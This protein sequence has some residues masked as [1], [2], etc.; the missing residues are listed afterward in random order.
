MR[1]QLVQVRGACITARHQHD[2]V[3]LKVFEA[4]RATPREFP[5]IAAKELD[6][7]DFITRCGS[8]TRTFRQLLSRFEKIADHDDQSGGMQR[9]QRRFEGCGVR[10]L[11]FGFQSCQLSEQ[12]MPMA[13]ATG[14]GEKC[15]LSAAGGELAD[16]VTL[17]LRDIR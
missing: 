4:H 7:G 2:F 10:K 11:P 3:A 16:H 12:S 17:A 6:G 1:L 9:A 14:Q 8:L 13:L 15:L 5:F